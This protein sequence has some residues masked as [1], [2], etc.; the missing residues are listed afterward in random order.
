MS[1]REQIEEIARATFAEIER[2]ENE[3][4]N[5]EQRRKETPQRAGIVD[6]GYAAKAARAEA[7]YLA[8][9]EA[10]NSMQRDLP[11]KART[12]IAEIRREYAQEVARQFAVDPSKLDL[13]AL[14]LLKSGIMKPD[15]YAAMLQEA[16][17]SGNTTM[18]RMIARYA[19]EA[20]EA[21]ERKYGEGSPQ[22]RELRAV[23]YSGNTDPA[24]AALEIFDG[25]AEI[26]SRCINN[27]SMIPMW[28]ELA[29]PLLEML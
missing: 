5:A 18:T 11:G 2:I 22:A 3:Y 17:R 21:A 28:D 15:E 24:A 4:K 16:Q 25:V 8:A 26:V 12:K 14:E 1:I 13:A 27:P 20:A 7:D 19:A 6:A 23:G 29:A 10:H 9:R